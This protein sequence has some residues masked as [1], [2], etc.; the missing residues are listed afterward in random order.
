[1]AW[2]RWNLSK[3]LGHRQAYAQAGR[4]MHNITLTTS[5]DAPGHT[6]IEQREPYEPVMLESDA[7]TVLSRVIVR[8]RLRNRSARY[9]MIGIGT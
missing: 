3:F 7:L 6:V 8:R 1:M 9:L 4:V 2:L 5:L